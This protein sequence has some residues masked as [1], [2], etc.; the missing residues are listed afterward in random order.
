VVAQLSGVNVVVI[1][2][3]VVTGPIT[4][5]ALGVE[6][7]GELA[8]ITVVLTMTPWLLDLGLSQ[9]L[10]RER[11]RGGPLP[12]LLGAALPVA[13]AGSMVGVALAIPLS[14]ALGH[15]RSV[16][17]T[18][19]QIGLFLAPVSVVLQTLVGLAIGESRW[20][21]FAATRLLASV[22][23]AAAIVVLALAGA[24][25]VGTA[26]AVYLISG[27]AS[28]AVL[29]P[30]V[31]GVRSLVLDRDRSRTAVAF[32]AK[33]WLGTVA[34]VVN[35]RFDQVLMAGLVAS[36][37]LGLYA[38]AV[39]V[40]S[41]TY[42]LS[43]A[44]SS[45]LYPRVAEGDAQL[46]ARACRV[47]V[48][49]VAAAAL[50]LAAM[51]PPM[52]PFVFGSPFADAVPMIIVLLL[53]SIPLAAV[54]VLAT[55]LNAADNPAAAMR[56]ELVGLALTLPALVLL[57]P[58]HGGMAAAFISVAAYSLRLAVLMR[59]AIRAFGGTWWSFLVP[60]PSDLRWAAQQVR[61]RGARST[62]A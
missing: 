60:T 8:A 38:V 34:G 56:A 24:L 6:G 9:W 41:L 22:L 25:S 61:R 19:L 44:V 20:R 54:V 42:G 62:E 29:A 47:T 18:Y 50:G 30:L 1:L 3:A 17:I 31:R 48:G 52:V 7:R 4:A 12:E 51:T 5:R 40:A 11:A 39:S 36:R 10:A 59:P 16:V 53:A 33:S 57:L 37:E 14:H 28:L 27:L 55:S 13:L 2:A 23:P 26:A 21:L 46:A 45:A 32:G 43:L 58:A 35:V 49:I 15:G